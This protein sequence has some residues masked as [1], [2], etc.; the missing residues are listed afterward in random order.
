M[1]LVVEGVAQ[2]ATGPRH[3]CLEAAQPLESPKRLLIVE[4]AFQAA[5]LEARLYL[6]LEANGRWCTG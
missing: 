4:V 3:R 2:M 6:S 1:G 5:A